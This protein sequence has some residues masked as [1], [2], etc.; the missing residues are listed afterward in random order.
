MKNLIIFLLFLIFLGFKTEIIS[1]QKALYA[2]IESVHQYGYY[3]LPTPPPGFTVGVGWMQAIDIDGK[4]T[5]SKVEV[6]WMRLHAIVGNKDTILTEESFDEETPLMHWYGLYNRNPWF[7]GDRLD[8]MPFTVENGV[9]TLE[10][11]TIPNRVFHWWN[12]FKPIIPSGT[13]R[14][15]FESKIRITGGAGVQAGIDYLTS[16]DAIGVVNKTEKE[17]GASD[18]FGNNTTDWQIITVGKP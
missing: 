4:G 8:F 1:P 3:S 11:G 13:T 9:L 17:A 5:P 10:P 6:D 7:A 18:W 2:P 12:T 14:V 15:W 16:A